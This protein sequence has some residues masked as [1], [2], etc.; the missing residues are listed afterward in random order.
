VA[1]VRMMC[2]Q[3]LR[4]ERVFLVEEA[5]PVCVVGGF[6][7]ILQGGRASGIARGPT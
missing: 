1:L 2:M 6:T 3:I 5:Q 7:Q 4:G